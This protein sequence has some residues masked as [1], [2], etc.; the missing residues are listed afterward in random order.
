MAI[1]RLVKH[2][3]GTEFTSCPR[4]ACNGTVEKTESIPAKLNLSSA[5]WLCQSCGACWTESSDT[6]DNTLTYVGGSCN[7]SDEPVDETYTV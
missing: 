5:S 7:E 1:P 3:N 2:E 4:D 6:P